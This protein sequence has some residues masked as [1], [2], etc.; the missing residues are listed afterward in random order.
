LS[1]SRDNIKLIVG[2][3]NPGQKYEQ[4]RHNAGVWFVNMLSSSYGG[5]LV[6][7]KTCKAKVAECRINGAPVILLTPEVYMNN[8][9]S[10]IA[11]YMRYFKIS[12]SQILIAHDELDFQPGVVRIKEGGGCAGHNGLKSI[13]SHIGGDDF[14]RLRI[15]IGHPGSADLVSDYVLSKSS[16][17]DFNLIDGALGDVLFNI[18]DIV[19]GDL[20]RAVRNLHVSL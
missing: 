10:E 11:K 18:D 13:K 9:G 12:P 1:D 20:Q 3:G 17:N 2:L 19:S 15:G 14:L 6:S 4:T 5:P 16:K 7:I 8:N